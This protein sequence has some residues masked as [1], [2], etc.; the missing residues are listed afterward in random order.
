MSARRSEPARRIDQPEPGFFTMRLVRGGWQ[1]PCAI[2]Y[3]EASG[4][5]TATVDGEAKS[6]IDPQ[7][8][9]VLLIWERGVRIEEWRFRDLEALKAWA[10]GNDPTHPCLSPRHR[11]NPMALTPPAV[12]RAVL[13]SMPTGEPTE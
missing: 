13:H 10:R 3:D 11:I 9:G 7:T 1:V 5:W 8:A 4:L 2:A 12:P 6:H